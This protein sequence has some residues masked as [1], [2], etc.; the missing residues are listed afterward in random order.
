[1]IIFCFANVLIKNETKTL[2][3]IM[4]VLMSGKKLDYTKMG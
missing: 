3:F 2:F 4:K 1:M